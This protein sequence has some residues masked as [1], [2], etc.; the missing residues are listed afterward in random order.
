MLS[1]FIKSGKANII[2]DGQFGSTGKGLIAAAISEYNHIDISIGRLS[3][4][5]GHTFYFNDKKC[6]VKMLPVS[7]II[8][9]RS[10]I[11]LSAGSVIDLEILIKEINEFNID[12]NRIVIH[13]RAAIISDNDK[14]IEAN[15]SGVASIA[16]TQSGSGSARANKIMRKAKLAQDYISKFEKLGIEVYE[17]PIHF[18]MDSGVNILIE[19]GQGFDLGLNFGYNYPHCT[20]VDVIPSAVLADI[21]IHPCYLGNVMMSIRTFPIRVGHI[22][23][24]NKIIGN[25]GPVYPDSNELSWKELNKPAELTT[26]TKRQRRIFTFSIQQYQRSLEFIRPDFVFLNFINYLREEDLIMFKKNIHLRK[27]DF[28]GYGPYTY[29][30]CPYDQ[31]ILDNII[32]KTNY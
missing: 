2:I 27:P 6:I 10:T 26:V 16:S 11:Y 13:P 18:Y 5:A 12:T 24:N 4:N 8:H 14:K 17:I 29:Q 3:P 9:K 7:S 19:T 21:G 30:V 20:S 32:Y 25:S 31:C 15:K 28:V 23:E 22:I 1:G